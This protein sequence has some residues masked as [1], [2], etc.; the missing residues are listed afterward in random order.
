MLRLNPTDFWQ[1]AFS[2]FLS[3]S[4]RGVLGCVRLKLVKSGHVAN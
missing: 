3:N 2:D 1:W 4:L